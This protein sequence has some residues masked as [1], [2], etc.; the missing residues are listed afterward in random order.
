MPSNTEHLAA[1]LAKIAKSHKQ[2]EELRQRM[3][4]EAEASQL[5]E[6]RLKLELEWM[7]VTEEEQKKQEVAAAAEEAEKKRR[8]VEEFKRRENEANEV[9]WIRKAEAKAKAEVAKK[10]ES[11]DKGKKWGREESLEVT[12]GSILQEK[13]VTWY[14]KEGQVC[15]ECAK[16]GEKCFWRNSPQA[17]TCR[18]CNLNK[19]TCVVGVGKEESEAGLSKKRKVAA[20]GKGRE[21]E[22]S[23]SELGLGV[24]A[25]VALL[26]EM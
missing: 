13:E 25:G 5:E 6:E 21:K 20:K 7:R 24:D 14:L 19:K 23:E 11:A 15:E 8:E 16:L 12:V 9:H 3:E 18:H 4:A 17:T 26:A 22:K 2:K 1:K 10:A